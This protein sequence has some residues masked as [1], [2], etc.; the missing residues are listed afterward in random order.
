MIMFSNKIILLVICA[1]L[2]LSS[3][4]LASEALSETQGVIGRV[5]QD[6][7]VTPQPGKELRLVEDWPDLYQGIAAS[8]LFQ[9]SVLPIRRSRWKII[10]LSKQ[11]IK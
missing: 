9:M 2:P 6:L 1:V 7:P 3:Q 10:H 8:R 11:T 4:V 5:E